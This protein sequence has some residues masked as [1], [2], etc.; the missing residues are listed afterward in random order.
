MTKDKSNIGQLYK[1]S[2]SEYEVHE[3]GGEWAAIEAKLS[4]VNF[5]HFGLFNF[6]IYYAL[7]I[8]GS[9][10]LNLILGINYLSPKQNDNINNIIPS[11]SSLIFDTQESSSEEIK[12]E[13][14]DEPIEKKRNSSQESLKIP[15]NKIENQANPKLKIE[16]KQAVIHTKVNTNITDEKNN[17]GIDIPEPAINHIVNDSLPI[18]NNKIIGTDT[19]SNF[20]KTDSIPGNLNQPEKMKKKTITIK[21]PDVIE[22]DTVIIL[23]KRK[24]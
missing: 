17:K 21:P 14:K 10:S 22:R 19:L 1:D 16:D 24:K 4:F 15:I 5:M 11:D 13:L 2:F 8:A 23:K 7:I 20:E 18:V 9:V 3:P 12:L 6:N